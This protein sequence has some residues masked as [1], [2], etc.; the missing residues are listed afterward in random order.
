MRKYDIAKEIFN[1][2]RCII[3]LHR[4]EP[5]SNEVPDHFEKSGFR[6]ACSKSVYHYISRWRYC[7][8]CG[9][10]ES[11]LAWSYKQKTKSYIENKK[12]VLLH[13]QGV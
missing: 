12:R 9:R 5:V 11:L 3:G 13:Y 2:I 1:K 4:W 8:N 7:P 6:I 10:I